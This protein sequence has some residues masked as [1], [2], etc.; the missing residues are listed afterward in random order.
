MQNTRRSS[1][2]QILQ[3]MLKFCCIMPINH[4]DA[5]GRKPIAAERGRGAFWGLTGRAVEF[6]PLVGVLHYVSETPEG[7]GSEGRICFTLFR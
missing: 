2:A 3:K 1:P 6:L 4:M 5:I 7:V